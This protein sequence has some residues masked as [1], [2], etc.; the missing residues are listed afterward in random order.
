MQT[1]DLSVGVVYPSIGH[2]PTKRAA[3]EYGHPAHRGF[4]RSVGADAVVVP[5]TRYPLLKDTFLDDVAATHVA[6]IPERDV[7]VLENDAVLFAAPRIRRHYPDATILH[8]AAASRLL[9][10]PTVVR[11]DDDFGRRLKRRMNHRAELPV[12]RACLTRYCDG[13]IA[14]SEYVAGEIRRFADPGFP[15]RVAEPYIQPEQ[16]EALSRLDPSLSGTD[17]VVVGEWREHKGVDLLVRAWPRVR[18]RHPDAELHVVGPG[19]PAAYADTLGVT[20]H[21]FV[22]DLE[23][24]FESASLYVHPA[25]TEA[26][27]VSVVEAL[28]AGLPAVVTET[29]GAKVAVRQVDPSL[30]VEP[31]ADALAAAVNRYFALDVAERRALAERGREAAADYT[32]GPRV[33]AFREGFEDLVGDARRRRA[34]A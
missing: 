19:Y 25:R 18:E 9:G 1:D 31:A 8:L 10:G 14:V 15:V 12:L 26:F 6:S 4:A 34:V 13:A 16:Y 22:E 5:L 30:V 29:T 7:Y 11:P 3:V 23:E 27:G 17:A 20:L 2:G 28:C 32:E 33:A 24:P 21:G